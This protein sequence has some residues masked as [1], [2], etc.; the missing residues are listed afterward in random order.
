M[1]KIMIKWNIKY[2][3]FSTH[4]IHDGTKLKERISNLTL[5]LY[6]KIDEPNLVLDGGPTQRHS[7]VEGWLS[8][9]MQSDKTRAGNGLIF[10]LKFKLY[11]SKPSDL[12]KCPYNP[13]YFES[14]LNRS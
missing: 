1:M 9:D 11:H 5:I 4:M 13:I 12:Y 10:Q 6:D 3:N 7:M 2:L 14:R 8:K